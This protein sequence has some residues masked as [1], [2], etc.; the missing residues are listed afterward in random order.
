MALTLRQLI[1]GFIWRPHRFVIFWIF[2]RRGGKDPTDRTP[3]SRS[4]D[5]P[6]E[7]VDWYVLQ[8]I[9]LRRTNILRTDCFVEN[10]SPSTIGRTINHITSLLDLMKRSYMIPS[11]NDDKI[12]ERFIKIAKE[13]TKMKTLEVQLINVMIYFC[14][15][16]DPVKLISGKM[17]NKRLR[18]QLYS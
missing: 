2:H 3:N 13:R 11:D 6:S 10:G 4:N 12:Y 5:L 9:G 8:H 14:G 18:K 7:L 17:N 16:I 1:H 15:V